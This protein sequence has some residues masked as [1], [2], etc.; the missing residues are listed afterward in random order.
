MCPYQNIQ[1]SLTPY[2]KS[3]YSGYSGIDMVF[4][5]E[6]EFVLVGNLFRNTN[7][8]YTV[9]IAIIKDGKVSKYYQMPDII[10]GGIMIRG[11]VLINQNEIIFLGYGGVNI[12]AKYRLYRYKVTENTLGEELEFPFGMEAESYFGIEKINSTSVALIPIETYPK[13]LNFK[14]GG[15]QIY[16]FDGKKILKAKPFEIEGISSNI[17]SV[18]GYNVFDGQVLI[19]AELDQGRTIIKLQEDGSGK[20]VFRRQTN[21]GNLMYFKNQKNELEMI[22]IGDIQ[23]P[24]SRSKSVFVRHSGLDKFTIKTLFESVYYNNPCFN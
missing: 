6:N 10:G 22:E 14:N 17:L 15:M 2:V 9:F 19:D 12:N 3:G 21:F 1:L 18:K 7:G 8:D 23:L 5:N 20:A 11:G 16:D 13:S 4:L 24:R